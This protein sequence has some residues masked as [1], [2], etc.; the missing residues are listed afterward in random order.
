MSLPAGS[1]HV[2]VLERAGFVRRTIVGRTHVCR[3]E[4][5]PLK[6]V[7]EWAEAYRRFW[8]QRFQGL[9]DLPAG[10]GQGDDGTRP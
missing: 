2:R 1:K 6:Q 4:A 9:D 7:V 10:S 8:E 5:A 3:L